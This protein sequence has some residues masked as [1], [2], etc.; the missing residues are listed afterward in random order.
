MKTE[1]LCYGHTPI[2]FIN[3]PEF[4]MVDEKECHIC[5]HEKKYS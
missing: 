1:K 2:F 5:I 4:E 3:D